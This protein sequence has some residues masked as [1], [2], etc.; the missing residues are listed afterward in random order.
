MRTKKQGRK[1]RAASK[2]NALG[3]YQALLFGIAFYLVSLLSSNTINGQQLPTVSSPLPFR[4]I[5]SASN[6]DQFKNPAAQ[7]PAAYQQQVARSVASQQP[8]NQS[9]RAP[10]QTNPFR[11]AGHT[12]NETA[13]RNSELQQVAMQGG[14]ALPPQTGSAGQASP[15]TPGAFAP[16]SSF[17]PPPLNTPPGLSQAPLQPAPA[18]SF[19]PQP[20][21]VSPTPM[22]A[23][24]NAIAPNTLP[25]NSLPNNTL[26][27]STTTPRSL[28]NYQGGA[29]M[30]NGMVDDYQPVPPPQ[31]ANGGFATMGDC[32]LI[33]PPS[34]YSAMSPY[35]GGCG[36]NV[37]PTA[38]DS[39][40]TPPPAQIAAPAVMPPNTLLPTSPANLPPAT[41]TPQSGA[42]PVGSLVTFGQQNYPV[43]VGQGLWGQ[44]VA[45]VPGQSFR[46][47]LRYFSF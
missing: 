27:Q 37:A 1:T 10:E 40:Y 8:T 9:V 46:N 15:Q 17:S 2:P 41:Y 5:G 34:S 29:A 6:V 24:P 21:T 30:Q 18:P 4:P 26:G 47:W 39:P 32:R 42:A 28:P 7:N 31:I 44:P 23:T 12:Y 33:T 36:G 13:Y 19:S 16:P 14:F 20:Q 45:F 43:Q 35:G 11:T 22:T 38:Y 25:N 3:L